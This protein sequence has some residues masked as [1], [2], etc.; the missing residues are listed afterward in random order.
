M[1]RKNLL[2]LVKRM[3][4]TCSVLLSVQ[5]QFYGFLVLYKMFE[6]RRNNMQ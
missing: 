3:T 1:S 5:L 2:K 6:I 4:V